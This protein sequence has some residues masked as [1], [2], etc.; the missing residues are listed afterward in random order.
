[1][2]T[3]ELK[4]GTSISNVVNL[5]IRT[6]TEEAVARIKK[7]SNVV[8]LIYS[9][10]TAYLISRLN[11][12]NV[13]NPIEV[14]ADAKMHHGRVVLKHATFQNRTEPLDVVV[15]GEVIVDAD[16]TT[17]DI[18]SGLKRLSVSGQ[19]LCPDHVA[20]VVDA[21]LGTLRGPL[22]VYPHTAKPIVGSL[23][24]DEP[25]LRSLDDGSELMVLG[26]LNARYELDNELLARRIKRIHVANGVICRQE[27]AEVLLPR[28]ERKG[29]R[30]RVTVI[31]AGHQL[32]E[33]AL[34]LSAS[35]LDAL[36]SRKLYCTEMVR[37]DEDVDAGALIKA[38]D[39][40]VVKGLF[41]CPAA[42]SGVVSEKLDVLETETIFYDGTLWLVDDS[43]ALA[44]ARFGYQDG[45]VTLIVLGELSIEPDIAPK[46]LVERLAQ[47]H[48]YG[49]IE[50]TRDQVA[51][52]QFRLG[53]DHGSLSEA[54][55]DE[56]EDEKEKAK[57]HRYRISNV[58]NLK[59]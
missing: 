45:P 20:G 33:R 16:V 58:V 5:D 23:T 52:L 12:S 44:A 10:E 11:I 2:E 3:R 56:T 46:V 53:V 24:L 41:I 59:L 43:S 1:M 35:L 15:L 57:P 21:K 42:L 4:P 13:V 32:V 38:V 9:P 47:V 31:P 39:S 34:V 48:N 50:G 37:I 54:M 19:L 14:A 55:P 29:G 28:L 18:E 51:A 25:Y 27:N 7:I 36:P 49:R 17:E 6:A 8:N 30:D 26:K 40:L 22:Q